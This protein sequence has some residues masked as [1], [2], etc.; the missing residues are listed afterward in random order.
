MLPAQTRFPI[1]IVI[2]EL[3][4]QEPAKQQVY[5]L[6]EVET[7]VATASRKEKRYGMSLCMKIGG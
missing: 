5:L 7:L 4:H 1:L 2:V 6:V 3:L